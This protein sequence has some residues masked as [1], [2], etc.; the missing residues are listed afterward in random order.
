MT[1]PPSP[2]VKWLSL[3]AQRGSGCNTVGNTSPLCS[4]KW[5]N[6]RRVLLGSLRCEHFGGMAVP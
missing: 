6:Y 2:K 1:F 3:L 5:S 4:K